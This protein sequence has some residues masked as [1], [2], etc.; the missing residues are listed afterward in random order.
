MSAFALLV[1]S[2]MLALTLVVLIVDVA[3]VNRRCC[4]TITAWASTHGYTLINVH[5]QWVGRDVK[6]GADG[7]VRNVH[8]RPGG[9]YFVVTGMTR[10]GMPIEGRLRIEGG[11]QG[12]GAK[13]V[14]ELVVHETDFATRTVRPTTPS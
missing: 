1:V 13:Q 4:R 2:V 6:R 11:F 12:Y 14:V 10:S 3:V 9:R 5:R 8:S 7:S